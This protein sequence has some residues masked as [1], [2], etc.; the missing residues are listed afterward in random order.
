M[1]SRTRLFL[2]LAAGFTVFAGLVV[3]AS[4]PTGADEPEGVVPEGA[5][6]AARADVE[7]AAVLLLSR[8][9]D[10]AIQVAYEG[11]KGW[12]GVP[13][14]PGKTETPANLS[15]VASRV[16]TAGGGPVPALTAAFGTA[17]GAGARVTVTWA[18]G[19]RA[20]AELASDGTWLVA[21]PG[22]TEVAS[23]VVRRGGRVEASVGRL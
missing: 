17:P 12:L 13:L 5:R 9:G 23:V 21:R 2:A 10:L 3:L 1:T 20:E 18:D 16:A 8:G 6:L 22:V 11:P 15:T 14:S 19:T 7:G 4:L